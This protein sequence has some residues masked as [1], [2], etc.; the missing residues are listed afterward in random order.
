MKKKFLTILSL[1]AA[2]LIVIT[3]MASNLTALATV[4]DGFNGEEKLYCAATVD[5]DFAD[6]R[7]LA[8]LTKAFSTPELRLN[9]SQFGLENAESIRYLTDAPIKPGALIDFEEFRHIIEIRLKTPG[10]NY[11]IEAIHSLEALDFVRSAGPSYYGEFFSAPNVYGLDDSYALE[12]IQAFE[13]QGLA[14]NGA[15]IKVGVIDSG[16][17]EHPDLEDNVVPGWD[18]VNNNAVT[19]NDING[20]GTHVSG[21]VKS[22]YPGVSLVPLK[23]HLINASLNAAI[24]AIYHAANEGIPIINCSFGFDYSSSLEQR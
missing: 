10:K 20:H 3:F 13:A 6:D 8:T 7:V 1:S 4:G 15:S 11:V 16:I 22:V 21:I 23:I 17:A 12:K 14:V 18:F 19:S 2:L 24:A 9:L 5:E